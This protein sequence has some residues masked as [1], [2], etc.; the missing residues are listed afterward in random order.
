MQEM[1]RVFGGMDVKGMF[2]SEETLVLNKNNIL[3]SK[4][5]LMGKRED[6][7]EDANLICEHIYDLALIGNKQLDAEAMSKFI[8]RS[9]KLLEKLV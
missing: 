6:K 9:N 1:S 3:I 2:P 5:L 8:E 4:V 7:K